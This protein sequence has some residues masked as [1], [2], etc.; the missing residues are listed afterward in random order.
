MARDHSKY[1]LDLKNKVSSKPSQFIIYVEGRNTE[2]SY[3]K[4]LKNSSC[5][6]V[7]VVE[8]VKVSGPVLSS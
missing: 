3:L 4:H 5:K 8:R 2:D 6:I 7:P 1:S